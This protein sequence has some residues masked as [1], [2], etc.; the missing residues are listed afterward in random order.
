MCLLL[1]VNV[2]GKNVSAKKSPLD[3][4]QFNNMLSQL[5]VIF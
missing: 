4:F 5:W 3:I 2:Y 1:N